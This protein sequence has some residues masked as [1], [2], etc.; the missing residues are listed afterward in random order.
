MAF[1]ISKLMI[2]IILLIIIL[3]IVIYLITTGKILNNIDT[4]KNSNNF[5]ELLNTPINSKTTSQHFTNTQATS[6]TIQPQPKKQFAQLK[7]HMTG[8]YVNNIK[9]KMNTINENLNDSRFMIL[10]NQTRVNNLTNR[11]NKLIETL[12]IAYEIPLKQK[13]KNQNIMNFY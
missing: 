12:K 9:N 4:F 7:E 6:T 1:K 5:V 11:T 3:G 13:T 2:V 10:D 8:T